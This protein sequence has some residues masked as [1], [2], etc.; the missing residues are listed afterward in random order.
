VNVGDLHWIEFQAR[1][2]HEQ[3]GRR[4]GIVVQEPGVSL[5]LPTILTIPLTTQVEALRFPGTV[6]IA[7]DTANGLRRDSV[8]LVFQLTA[9]DRRRVGAPLGR[10]SVEVMDEV[11]KALDHVFGRS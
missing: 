8:A 6:L 2:G 1:G 10:N 4:P 9:V 5:A 7:P 11:W 3:A